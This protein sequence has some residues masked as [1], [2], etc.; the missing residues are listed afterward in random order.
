M[1]RY[2]KGVGLPI[3]GLRGDSSVTDVAKMLERLD[4][5]MEVNNME[6]DEVKVVIVNKN[7]QKTIMPNLY[8]A[9]SYAEGIWKDYVDRIE[10]TQVYKIDKN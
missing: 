9:K 8:I 6:P 7:G 3:Q 10:V 2:G 1:K 5:G 4:T